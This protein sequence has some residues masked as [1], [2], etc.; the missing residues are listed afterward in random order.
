MIFVKRNGLKRPCGTQPA[1]YKT[2]P[3]GLSGWSNITPGAA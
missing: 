2:Q 3:S 1:T